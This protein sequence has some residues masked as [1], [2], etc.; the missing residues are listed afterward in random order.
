MPAS[1]PVLTEIEAALAGAKIAW[2]IAS[3]Q[4]VRKKGLSGGIFQTP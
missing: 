2:P 1:S 4:P 3:A